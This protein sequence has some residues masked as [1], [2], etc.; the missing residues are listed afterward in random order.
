M[1]GVAHRGFGGWPVLP[2][3]SAPRAG[4]MKAKWA[5]RVSCSWMVVATYLFSL[6][7][8]HGLQMHQPRLFQRGEGALGIFCHALQLRKLCMLDALLGPHGLRLECTDDDPRW[9]ASAAPSSSNQD[10]DRRKHPT[11]PCARILPVWVNDAG[12][13][14]AKQRKVKVG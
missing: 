3:I 8:I 9:L 13:W 11:A 12:C 10:H 4:G 14:S 2:I 5:A 7:V 6:L 1:D